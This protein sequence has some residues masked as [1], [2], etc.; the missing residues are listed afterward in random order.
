MTLTINV[1]SIAVENDQDIARAKDVLAHIFGSNGN[2][3]TTSAPLP[4]PSTSLQPQ[5]TTP[6]APFAQAQAPQTA[7]M[8]V[9]TTPAA[10]LIATPATPTGVNNAAT[11]VKGKMTDGR[12]MFKHKR[13][14]VVDPSTGA[15]WS[16]DCGC[17]GCRGLR[18]NPNPPTGDDYNRMAN[19]EQAYYGGVFAMPQPV[20][21]Q[22]QPQAQAPVVQS[23]ASSFEQLLAANGV[24]VTPS[25]PPAQP[26]AQAKPKF[27]PPEN[28]AQLSVPQAAHLEHYAMCTGPFSPTPDKPQGTGLVATNKRLAIAQYVT[29]RT[30]FSAL[31]SI[32]K[33]QGQITKVLNQL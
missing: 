21:Y 10:S 23:A 17:S 8:A 16:E 33:L 1:A 24:P 3:V 9:P 7:P 25:T 11:Q 6:A 20:A 5:A 13:A 12:G 19:A 27:T 29:G 22:P 4:Q 26:Q 28:G 31:A 15:V 32:P 14:G 30:P 18:A 2:A